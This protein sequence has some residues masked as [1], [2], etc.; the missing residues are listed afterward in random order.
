VN[1]SVFTI[2]LLRANLLRSEPRLKRIATYL[3]KAGFRIVILNWD[4]TLSSET[5]DPRFEI[6]T[7]QHETPFQRGF[8]NLNAYFLWFIWVNKTLSKIDSKVIIPADLDCLIPALIFKLK[9]PRRNSNTFIIYDQYDNFESRFNGHRILSKLSRIIEKFAQKFVTLVIIPTIN[10]EVYKRA[11]YLIISNFS[12]VTFEKSIHRNNDFFYG[13]LMI[14]G[15]GLTQILSAAKALI[16]YKFV[17]AGYGPLEGEIMKAAA[18]F[19]NVE[20]IGRFDTEEELLRL[21]SMSKVSLA[22]YDPRDHNNIAT[23]SHKIAHGCLSKTPL[24]AARGTNLGDLVSDLNLGYVCDFKNSQE[25][26]ETMQLAMNE[27]K[28]TTIAFIDSAD[29]YLQKNAA[30]FDKALSEL[31]SFIRNIEGGL[32]IV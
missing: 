30:Q 21:T 19:A 26:K 18:D 32:K 13:G 29:Q 17:F 7:F 23:A 27:L 20:F 11:N 12:N 31:E 28:F 10:R 6:Y 9:K 1:T 2:V 22:I 5:Y 15:R 16:Q 25:L 8:R 24:I 14:E 4:R 3:D